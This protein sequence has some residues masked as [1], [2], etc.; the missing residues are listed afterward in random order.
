MPTSSSRIIL[1][2]TNCFLRLYQSSVRPLMGQDIGG[3]RLLTLKK[4]IEE[5]QNNQNLVSNY[6]SIAS[7]PKHDELTNSAIKLSGIN[8]G[9]IKDSQ[10]ELAPYAKS[11]LASYCK[12]QNIEIIR[13]L[14]TPDLELLATTI[15]IKGIIATDEWP[16][17]LVATDLMEDPE[18]YK[19]GL[20]NSLELLHLIQENGK[21]SPEDRR[22][23][24][25]SWVLYREKLLGNW[26][27][28]YQRLFGESADSLDDV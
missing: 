28:D 12:Q 24:V 13:R 4:L 9:K 1:V 20:L 2:D 16:L 18:E 15:I 23:T 25:R 22:K 3:Y 8:K 7:G 26:R 5:F 19:I 6:P 14:S 17:R 10:K 11:F 21:I 27:E